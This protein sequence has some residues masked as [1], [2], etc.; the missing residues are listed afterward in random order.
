[1][2][3]EGSINGASVGGKGVAVTTTTSGVGAAQADRI[4]VN[5]TVNTRIVFLTLFIK[6]PFLLSATQEN[7][8]L[9]HGKRS[10]R[11]GM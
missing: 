11:D 1:V 8:T 4:N 10:T 3:G 6:S 5:I 9:H 7:N 2:V